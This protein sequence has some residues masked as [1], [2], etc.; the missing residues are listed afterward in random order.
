MIRIAALGMMVLAVGMLMGC[1]GGDEPAKTDTEK[2]AEKATT[3]LSKSLESAAKQAAESAEAA[4]KQLQKAASEAEKAVAKEVTPPADAAAQE[5]EGILAKVQNLIK[6]GKLA[7]ADTQLKALEAKKGSLP[8]SLQD[9]IKA[10]RE[11]LA[12]AMKAAEAL[13]LPGLPK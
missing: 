12:A 5:A 3:D 1:G 10:L 2:A 6:S 4:T 8:A 13:K 9:K 11:T 7:D